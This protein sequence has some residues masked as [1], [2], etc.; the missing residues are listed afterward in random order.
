MAAT[1][2]KREGVYKDLMEIG[3]FKRLIK[4]RGLQ[5]TLQLGGLAAFGVIVYAGLFG[6]PVG[7]ENVSSTFTWLIWWTLIPVTMLVGSRIWCLAC[8]WIAIGEWLQRLAFW[9]KG[10]LTLSL[11]LKVPKLLR[12]FGLMLVFFLLLHWADST[13]HLA[14]R[15]ET[16]VYLALGMFAV[17]TVISLVFEKRSFCRY[18]CPIGAIIAPYSL[19]APIELRNKDTQVC[20]S[21]K[22]RDCF[23]GNE[24]GYGCPQMIYPW[25]ID[26]N[27]HCL[28]C[29][30]CAKT[31]PHDNIAIN[32][33]KPFQDIFKEGLGFLRTPDITFSLS[34]IA[35]VLLGIIPFHNLEMTAAY[36]SLE[37]KLAGS[38]GISAPV[39][40]T[41]AF[42]MMGII[43]VGVFT[44]ISSLTRRMAG[45]ARYNTKRIFIW[46]AL[47]FIPLAISMHLGHNYFHLLEEGAVI[48]PNLS[49]PFG[50][51][52]N[53]F[54][55]AGASVTVLPANVISVLQFLTIG[56][57]FLASGYALY[58]LSFNMFKKRAQALSSIA[59][60][61]VLLVGLASFYMWVLTIPMSMRF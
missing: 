31:C 29:T 43:F 7:G 2:V 18:F 61:G 36:G 30:E 47:A 52:W 58:R 16:T 26:R 37:G 8:P 15:P 32:I 23:K 19:V 38:L 53:L 28:L 46:F 9:H 54:G 22:T 14:L 5:F 6:T 27:T 55:T 60:M 40:R 17:A 25:A 44:G 12:N 45:D 24:K 34:V 10:K 1:T 59:I 35:I 20:R 42:L 49:D 39:L 41:I 51:G 57:G 4:W 56:F 11:N 50:F 48:I 21:C 3:W 33:R 13:F